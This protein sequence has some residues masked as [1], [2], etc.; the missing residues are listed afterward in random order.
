MERLQN[1]TCIRFVPHYGQ[2]NYVFIN[3]KEN[4]GCF[5]VIG[6]HSKAEIPHPVN[7]ETPGCMKHQ[8]TIE[9]EFLHILGLFHEQSRYDRDDHVIIYWENITEGILF[10][11]INDQKALVSG[12]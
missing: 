12:F 10:C 4:A 11:T 6:Y 3:N 8:G 1:E 5:A 9:H 7:F 2:K